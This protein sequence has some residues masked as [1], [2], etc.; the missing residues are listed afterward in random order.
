MSDGE[1]SFILL[2][3][4]HYVCSACMDAFSSSDLFVRLS[5]GH[6]IHL[7]CMFMVKSSS[8]PLCRVG[9]ERQLI[10]TFKR[11]DDYKE[12]SESTVSAS[13]PLADLGIALE[14]GIVFQRADSGLVFATPNTSVSPAPRHR[15]SRRNRRRHRS[16]R[17]EDDLETDASID[18][19]PS[20]RRQ[21][22]YSRRG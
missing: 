8:C 13:T 6:T 2:D 14:S 19:E 18:H 17:W 16:S 10:Q 22:A 20:F 4:A 11:V 7:Y 12:R 3:P 1:I 9:Y 21:N 15:R 5:C